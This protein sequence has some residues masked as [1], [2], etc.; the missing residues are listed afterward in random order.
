MNL[1]YQAFFSSECKPIFMN[2]LWRKSVCGQLG[3]ILLFFNLGKS[4]CDRLF[5]V[6]FLQ[7]FVHLKL[8]D[9]CIVP[10]SVLGISITS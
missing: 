9:V 10:L 1:S 5:K 3:I 7:R 2:L 8:N 6:F 4:I